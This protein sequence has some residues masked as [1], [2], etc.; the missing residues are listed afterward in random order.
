MKKSNVAQMDAQYLEKMCCREL[1]I[2]VNGISKL[3][4]NIRKYLAPT[5]TAAHSL[6]SKYGDCKLE[7]MHCSTEG[8]WQGSVG[9]NAST[10]ELHCENDCTYTLISVPKQEKVNNKYP[11]YNFYLNLKEEKHLV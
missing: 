8:L 5:I 11:E 9:V 3:I 6:Q 4:P 1:Q 10:S 2:A 7:Q